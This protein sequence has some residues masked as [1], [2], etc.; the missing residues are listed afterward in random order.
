MEQEVAKLKSMASKMKIEK[1]VIGSLKNEELT[2]E[3]VDKYVSIMEQVYDDNIETLEN[4][5][6]NMESNGVEKNGKQN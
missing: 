4:I 2:E 3:Y 6:E 5:I 1:L